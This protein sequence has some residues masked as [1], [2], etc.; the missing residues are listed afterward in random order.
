MFF[1]PMDEGGGVEAT[2]LRCGNGDLGID[3]FR[4]VLVRRNL[5]EKL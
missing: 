5:R 3:F 2:C 1:V 4:V